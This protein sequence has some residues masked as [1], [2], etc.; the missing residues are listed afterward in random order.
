MSITCTLRKR[1]TDRRT[2]SER[3]TSGRPYRIA[4]RTRPHTASAGRSHT[5][6]TTLI[7]K[8]VPQEVV[9]RLLDHDSPQMTSHYASS[10]LPC[11][12][13]RSAPGVHRPPTR[14]PAQSRIPDPDRRRVGLLPRPLR[15]TRRVDRHLRPCL[16]HALHP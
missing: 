14:H 16:R 8:D 5:F 11:R 12:G 1:N 6:G 9:R 7:N 15:E 4:T 3:V 2:D 10:G 13:H